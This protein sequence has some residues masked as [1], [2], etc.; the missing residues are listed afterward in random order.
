MG[1]IHDNILRVRED[2]ARYAAIGNR[3]VKEITLIGVSKFFPAEAAEDAVKAGLDDLGENR[4]A[5]LIEKQEILASHDLFPN[6]HMIGTLQRKKVKQ[7][8]G[9][10]ALIHSVDTI[11]LMEEISKRSI[12]AGIKSPILLQINISHEESKHGFGADDL[13]G[14]IE[15]LPDLAG[16]ELQG[17]MTMA[18][19]T[20]DEK[21][22]HDVFSGAQELFIKIKGELQS[23]TFQILSMGMS[24]DYPIAILHGA[25]HLRIGTAIFGHRI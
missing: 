7:I 5:D 21:I 3:D 17:F 22:L 19:L 11:G 13:N 14:I 20:Q 15:I 18:P 25:T 8:I 16:I 6:W 4:V 24:N 2:I 9:K 1:E 10:A 12:E 23:P